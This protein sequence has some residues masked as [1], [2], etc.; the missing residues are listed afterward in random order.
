[1]IN[2][3]IRHTPLAY[4]F[5]TL[6]RDEAFSA[7]LARRPVMEILG[8]SARE[9]NAPLYYILLHYWMILL[10]SSEIAI[11]LLSVIPHTL[12]TIF[13][14]RFF[15][16]VV[17]KNEA[18]IVALSVFFNPMLLTYAFEARGY[19]WL[20][21]FATVSMLSFFRERWSLYLAS[22]VAGL[23][24]HAYLL[25]LVILQFAYGTYRHLAG[26]LNQTEYKRFLWSLAFVIAIYLAWIPALVW[27]WIRSAESWIYPIDLQLILS[28]LGNLFTS[29]EGTPGGVWILTSWLSLVL[30][31]FFAIALRKY[32]D[33]GSFL[34]LWIF[35]P[36]GSIL[37]ASVIKPLYVNRYLIF[38]A[39]AESLLAG[40]GVLSVRKGKMQI[41]IT[42][43]YFALL[44]WINIFLPSVS[45]RLDTRAIFQELNT[46]VSEETRLYL[47]VLL[48]FDAVYY[49]KF[50]ENV[51]IYHKSGGKLPS[52]VGLVLIPE[53]VIVDQIVPGEDSIVL[54]REGRV[55]VP[56]EL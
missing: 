42:V 8:I 56:Q 26:R 48:Y 1:M 54:N 39:V 16:S 20:A 5:Q 9:F 18:F 33:L 11:R 50:P 35:F 41:G 45:R 28:V 15:R 53:E 13:V 10:G 52:Y 31:G 23:Y 40:L 21:L 43:L 36:L 22:T 46:R 14:Y 6:W 55:V 29:Y 17:S 47:D 27:Q 51:R 12:L 2:Y 7:L 19:S 24:T 4:L 44:A 34:A 49:Y 38:V 32:Q 3:L 25:L 37:L 30:L